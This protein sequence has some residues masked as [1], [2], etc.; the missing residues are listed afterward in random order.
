MLPG[1]RRVEPIHHAVEAGLLALIF[2]RKVHVPARRGL[3]VHDLAF[4]PLAPRLAFHAALQAP[5]QIG[6]GD[7]LDGVRGRRYH[8]FAITA[9][10][11]GAIAP[12]LRAQRRRGGLG[13]AAPA[14]NARQ[15]QTRRVGVA[16][17]RAARL[18]LA[19]TRCR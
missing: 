5:R 2:E 12:S 13:R 8:G 16:P 19:L 7:D 3:E 1:T 14:W 9:E 15:S 11:V 4:H 17:L 6:Y 18:G 10:A